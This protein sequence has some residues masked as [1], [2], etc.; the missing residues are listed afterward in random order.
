[1]TNAGRGVGATPSDP[2]MRLIKR[3]LRNFPVLRIRKWA[4]TTPYEGRT[5]EEEKERL[6]RDHGTPPNGG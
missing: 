1:M 2:I 4:K 3:L 5:T 6:C